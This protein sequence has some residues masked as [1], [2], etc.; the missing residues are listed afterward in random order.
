VVYLSALVVWSYAFALEGPSLMPPSYGEQGRA[1]AVID[2]LSRYGEL[3]SP[4]ALA[5][6]KGLNNNTPTL[7]VLREAFKTTSWE[8]LRERSALVLGNCIK[9]NVSGEL[10]S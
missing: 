8:F 10:S 1:E 9:L 2:Y 3:S 6:M 7:E 4:V 5:T